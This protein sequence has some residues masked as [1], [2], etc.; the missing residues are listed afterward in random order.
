MECTCCSLF[1]TDC[2]FKINMACRIIRR[3]E[4]QDQVYK[5]C[6]KWWPSGLL[7]DSEVTCGIADIYIYRSPE[8]LIAFSTWCFHNYQL[9]DFHRN[10]TT[11]LQLY[12][13]PIAL[14]Q[15]IY[16]IFQCYFI[17]TK[18]L[19]KTTCRPLLTLLRRHHLDT[20]DDHH[21]GNGI[22]FFYVRLREE[23]SQFFV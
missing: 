23:A 5:H 13:L 1:N 7:L 14:T 16:S 17:K 11:Y 18:S 22:S 8:Q 9:Y 4:Q 10:E 2:I 20:F 21:Q 6:N 12:S 19:N 15:L 3:R